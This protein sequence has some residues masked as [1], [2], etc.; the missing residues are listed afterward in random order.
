MTSNTPGNRRWCAAWLPQGALRR[1]ERG[2]AMPG[3]DVDMRSFR[4]PGLDNVY[5][6]NMFLWGPGLMTS[7]AFVMATVAER[8]VDDLLEKAKPTLTG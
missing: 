8:I 7:S 3:A 6:A 5:M 4:L 2:D 1:Y